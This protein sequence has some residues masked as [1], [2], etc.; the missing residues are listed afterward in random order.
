MRDLKKSQRDALDS[1]AKR[2]SATWEAGGEPPGVEL[3]LAAGG[4]WR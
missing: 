4:G 3:I 1:V 2:F